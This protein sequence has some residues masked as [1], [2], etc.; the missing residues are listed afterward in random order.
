M[1]GWGN[2]SQ[3]STARGGLRVLRLFRPRVAGGK[4]EAVV[5]ME[6][7]FAGRRGYG[8]RPCAGMYIYCPGIWLQVSKGD[9]DARKVAAIPLQGG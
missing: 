5:E 3:E 6:E 9:G 7:A 2:A 1:A 4:V 8:A